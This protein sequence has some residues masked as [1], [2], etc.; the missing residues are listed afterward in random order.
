MEMRESRRG[1]FGADGFSGV[2]VTEKRE[3]FLRLKDSYETILKM[4]EHLQ[5]IIGHSQAYLSKKI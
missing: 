1:N 3:N 2:E 4:F 5:F